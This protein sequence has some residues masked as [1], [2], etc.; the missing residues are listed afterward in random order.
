MP[1]GLQCPKRADDANHN[2]GKSTRTNL[3]SA[4]LNQGGWQVHT[5]H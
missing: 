5:V 1:D 3:I 4:T 2:F